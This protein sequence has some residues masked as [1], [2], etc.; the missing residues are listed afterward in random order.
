MKNVKNVMIPARGPQSMHA[1]LSVL[2]YLCCAIHAI[3][4]MLSS[5]YYLCCAKNMHVA[6]LPPLCARH[7]W[8]MRAL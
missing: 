2:G 6:M 8:T 1:M 3:Y 7:L 4:A 5:P